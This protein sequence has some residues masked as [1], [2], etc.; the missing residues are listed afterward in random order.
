ML[1]LLRTNTHFSPSQKNI[2]NGRLVD[3][4]GSPVIVRFLVINNSNGKTVKVVAWSYGY[5][6]SNGVNAT[7]VGVLVRDAA[8]RRLG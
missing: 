3:D 4:F 1:T 5:L 6:T 2:V 7:S 8:G